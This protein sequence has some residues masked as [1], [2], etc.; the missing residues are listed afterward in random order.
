MRMATLLMI[1]GLLQLTAMPS[2]A[3][4]GTAGSTQTREV[5]AVV[6][7]EEIFMDEL[8]AAV[9][10]RHQNLD[11]ET[12]TAWVGYEGALQRLINIR[13]V[14]QEARDVGL[15]ERPE[16][17]GKVKRYRD[18][19]LI[20]LL[21]S[22]Q[23]MGLE[24][25]KSD[26]DEIYRD[27]VRHWAFRAI[28]FED[29]EQARAFRDELE[30]EE[31]FDTVGE[32]YVREG[33]ADWDGGEREAREADIAPE[34]AVAFLGK[35]AGSVTPV[36]AAVDRYFVFKLTGVSYPENPTARQRAKRRALNLKK[37]EVLKE[38]V[39]RLIEKY[40][41]VDREVLATAGTGDFMDM[42]KD[43]RVLTEIADEDPVL[44]ADLV[45]HL[46]GKFYHG[47]KTSD[48]GKILRSSPEAVLREVLEERMY[49]KEARETRIDR[50]DRYQELVADYENSLV[51]GM[52]L[53]EFLVPQA[54]VPEEEIRTAYEERSDEFLLPLT[55]EV[56]S[57]TFNGGD[58]ARK[59]LESLE[60]GADFKWLSANA[61]GLTED[62]MA[63][64]E[65][66]LDTVPE[67]LRA[68][69]VDADAGDIRLYEQ[70]DGLFKV[71]IVRDVPPFNERLKQAIE[72]LAAE[73]RDISEITIYEEKLD[74]GPAGQ[75]QNL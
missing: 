25:D 32:R 37:E 14:L 44:V 8:D 34:I 2:I 65:L 73:L 21:K 75:G 18:Q 24:P 49:L 15:E 17:S 9:A 43:P 4:N 38:H 19:I 70:D 45:R 5:I 61:Q 31:D 68:V 62:G 64:E 56:D 3:S 35:E 40:V 55:V 28:V 11:A 50:T 74:K 46:K 33:L 63:R 58:N 7:G 23:V 22:R 71:V 59:A 51:F 36:I 29:L 26:V 41:T 12:K 54:Q 72:D 47:A 20:K 42:E 1:L 57:L 69:L 27:E 30:G 13:L 16:I 60:R 39:D 48:Y 67:G 66:I 53:E 6:N 52:Y 10:A